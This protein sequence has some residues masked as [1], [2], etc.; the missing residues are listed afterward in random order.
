M[1]SDHGDEF[2]EHGDVGHAQGVYQELVH[3]PLIIRAPGAV[4]RP[5]RWSRPTSRPWTCS[6]PC[7]SW[8]GCRC[9]AGTQGSSL[10]PLAA[11]RGGAQP[12]RGAE[13]EP[14]AS[15]AASRSARYRFIHGG[16]ARVELYDELDDP[17]E[18]KNLAASR[19][20]ALRQMRNVFGLLYAYENRWRKRPGAPPPTCNEAFYGDVGGR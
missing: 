9:P 2:W 13:P 19:P 6:P 16:P 5:A 10:L 8:P 1:I 4:S 15:P 11:R 17:L 12:A 3:I 20:I 14:G 18:Q 7:W